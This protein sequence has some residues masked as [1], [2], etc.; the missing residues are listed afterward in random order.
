MAKPWEIFP[1]EEGNIDLH[2]RPV[3]K[4]ADGSISTVRS[5]SFN[6]DGNEI[7]V[8][9]V[10]DDGRI[11][12]EQEAIENYRRTG[13][14]LG[15]FKT[16]EAATRYAE[17][18]H[19][20]QD[21]EYSAGSYDRDAPETSPVPTQTHGVKSKV[22]KPWERYANADAVSPIVIDPTS[23]SSDSVSQAPKT[24][25]WTFYAAAEEDKAGMAHETKSLGIDDLIQDRQLISA[26]KQYKSHSDPE[27]FKRPDQEVIDDYISQMRWM[28]SNTVSAVSTL[29]DTL[30]ATDEDKRNLSIMRD[31][32]DQIPAF[33][34]EGG[35]GVS[36]L[37]SNLWR[38]AL[39]PANLVGGFAGK[40]ASG[41]VGKVALGAAADAAISTGTNLTLQQ[42]DK[43]IGRREEI[44]LPEAALAGA[45]GAGA[46]LAGNVIA[47]GVVAGVRRASAKARPPATIPEFAGAAQGT[48]RT[49]ISGQF[50]RNG[51]PIEIGIVDSALNE[52]VDFRH[53]LSRLRQNLLERTPTIRNLKGQAKDSTANTG[54]G[55]SP[56][57]DDPFW[58]SHVVQ[59]SPSRVLTLLNRGGFKAEISPIT[60]AGKGGITYEL[61]P[62][63][64][65]L[66][67]IVR[68][69]GGDFKEVGTY[70]AAKRIEYDRA[71]K[72][73]DPK[74]GESVLQ[75]R[76]PYEDPYF[77][78][79]Q[80]PSLTLN[81][82]K[83]MA[84]KAIATLLRDGESRPK[85]LNAAQD[86]SKLMQNV[87]DYQKTHGLLTDEGYKLMS[88]RNAANAYVPFYQR[89]ED[90][91]TG[92]IKE[93]GTGTYGR[94]PVGKKSGQGTLN[95]Y[96]PF[97]EA[98]IKNIT[99]AVIASDINLQKRA[100]IKFTEE[101][102]QKFP[103]LSEEGTPLISKLTA[104]DWLKQVNIPTKELRS[105]FRK[106][107]MELELPD[108][109]TWADIPDTVR[110]WAFAN[111]MMDIANKDGSYVMTHYV[112]GKPEH[113]RINNLVIAKFMA[114]TT[115]AGIDLPKFLQKTLG[116][117]QFV[118]RA[119]SHLITKNPLYLMK[120]VIR[121]AISA[122]INSEFGH[123]PFYGFLNGMVQ[124]YTNANEYH[125][126]LLHGGLFGSYSREGLMGAAA[127]PTDALYRTAKGYLH[128]N[129]LARG[130]RGYGEMTERI[131]QATR[132]AEYLAAR[133][134]GY[135]E[136]VAGIVAQDITVNFKNRG[137][138]PMVNILTSTIPFM[139]ANVNGMHK[140][141]GRLIRNPAKAVPM[142]T[143]MVVLPELASWY[144]SKDFQ[145][146]QQI[147]EQVKN[148][149]I[150]IPNFDSLDPENPTLNTE[151]PFFMIP[152]ALDFG[153]AGSIAR[154]ILDQSVRE[155][156]NPGVALQKIWQVLNDSIPALDTPAIIDPIQNL[157]SNK[158]FMGNMITT[159]ALQK[160]ESAMPDQVIKP[161]T[162]PL[163][164]QGVQ[165]LERG[166]R[167]LSG[168]TR[169]GM[170]PLTPVEADYLMEN[171][172]PGIG[173]LL[174]DF[175][176]EMARTGNAPTPRTDELD[177]RFNSPEAVANGVYS[178]LK[179]NF[180]VGNPIRS[181]TQIERIYDLFERADAAKTGLG[182]V[183]QSANATSVVRDKL[184]IPETRGLMALATPSRAIVTQFAS[185]D[186][187][188]RQITE[189]DKYTADQKRSLIDNLMSRKNAA[190]DHFWLSV[191]RLAKKDENVGAVFSNMFGNTLQD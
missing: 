33:W 128:N 80:D 81:Q 24:G 130:W 49:P 156:P 4:N 66:T 132:F 102:A 57:L 16:P 115:K 70:L 86:Y 113:Y 122:S 178:V 104:E 105:Q 98:T 68:E 73:V 87:L 172:F 101:V 170:V 25:P 124:S 52:M 35:S 151:M 142:I 136:D 10:S 169:H 44:S 110:A 134:A 106:L 152:K 159:P 163:V 111:N 39:D 183:A 74:T 55:D 174:T 6:M 53:N 161:S 9:T 18:L 103:E 190:A 30:G 72:G 32:W 154:N 131:E 126:F 43:N 50:D 22:Q 186:K 11:M 83:D 71:L 89:E 165:A 143:A 160:L 62:E 133:R 166:T 78:I 79:K 121:D 91:L 13:K 46:S 137:A 20:D 48:V 188:V 189:S 175:L 167:F 45:V 162:N 67:Q 82:A 17:R 99:S 148:T 23:G 61:T 85:V 164:T 144:L 177:L 58:A 47:S 40:A 5:M 139:R 108:G 54:V 65:P 31:R 125:K 187:A 157:I 176:G 182:K 173:K 94:G 184:S 76:T 118:S 60:G 149:N 168:G 112:D 14:H 90:A 56:L 8:P 37:A 138:N 51:N 140:M 41:I 69:A 38:G 27:Y 145:E 29:V 185:I 34:D 2:T 77:Y 179:K 158:D 123:V 15:K 181:N 42:V 109:A 127:T 26:Y 19:E 84:K 171:Y 147:P 150:L 120:A 107:G 3:V 75:R 146:Y 135:T 93:T 7:L 129:F 153:W 21:K 117:A 97:G 180:V 141:L 191:S 92:H 96:M 114:D 64:K 116:A 88:E 119:K 95:E 100:L 36:G 28:D 63:I 59:T 12:S 155:D 1:Q